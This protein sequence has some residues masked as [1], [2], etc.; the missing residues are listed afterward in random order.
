[1]GNFYGI[2]LG[3]KN[4]IWH[5]TSSLNGQDDVDKKELP[6]KFL[7]FQLLLQSLQSSHTGCLTHSLEHGGG[8]SLLSFLSLNFSFVCDACR[9]RMN[10]FSFSYI[11]VY[12][13]VQV[14]MHMYLD[15]SYLSLF[16]T[17]FIEAAWAYLPSQHAA[18]DFLSLGSECWCHRHPLCPPALCAT[19]PTMPT[20][21]PVQCAHLPMVSTCPLCPLCPPTQ[22]AHLTTMPTMLMDS[23]CPPCPPTYLPTC[24]LCPPCPPAH[25]HTCPLCPPAPSAYLPTCSPTHF[26]VL[27]T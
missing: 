10:V 1:M 7:L 16:Y 2:I 14:S 13:C 3:A 25:L 22:C 23:T 18:G 19:M 26:M 27:G 11:W 5:T 21:P 17:S 20:C 4:A 15:R 9:R 8:G 12:A 24:L 6:R